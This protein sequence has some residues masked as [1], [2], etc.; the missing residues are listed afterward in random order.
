MIRILYRHRSG[1]IVV[2]LPKEQLASA[3][4]DAQARLW[5]D[6]LNP[7]EEESK[8]LFHDLFHFHPLAIDDAIKETHVPKLDDY[9]SYLYLVFH[10]VSM[11]DEKMDIHTYEL[12]VF[13]GANYLITMHEDERESI[14]KLWGREC[15]E[16]N[17]LARG[18][19][20]LLYELLDRQVDRYIPL[21]DR[22]EQQLEALGDAIFE[23]NRTPAAALLNDILTAKSSALRLHRIL[24]PQRQ[25]LQRLARN[26][27]AVVPADA[28]IYFNDTYD[29]LVRLTDLAESM[30]D[31]AGS[32]IDTHLALVNNRM[33]EVIKVLTI[34]STIFIPLSFVAGVYGM[35]FEFMPELHWRIGYPLIWLIFITIIAGMLSMF[36]RRGWL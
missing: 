28:R 35:N 11:G 34:I 8:W 20:Y 5:I 10:T 2:D 21:M 1:T 26:D 36:R 24:A 29:H 4:R 33:N 16:Q 25:L 13:L 14:E 9:S 3:I 19:A 32:T 27:Y 6:M 18:P 17:G 12:D 15:H 31:L 7:S 22:F 30:R 23:Q